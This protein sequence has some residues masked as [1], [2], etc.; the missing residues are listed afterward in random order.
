MAK[1]V[2][3]GM[4]GDRVSETKLRNAR[5]QTPTAAGGC[6]VKPP[7]DTLRTAADLGFEIGGWDEQ[8]GGLRGHGHDYVGSH[9]EIRAYL[10]AWLTCK[11]VQTLVVAQELEAQEPGIQRTMMCLRSSWPVGGG[12]REWSRQATI[13]VRPQLPFRGERI[14]IPDAIAPFFDLD[15]L[16]VGN[17]SCMPQAQSISCDLLA[18]RLDHRAA[19]EGAPLPSGA[20]AITIT[21]AATAEF[22]RAWSM[23]V[24]QVAQDLVATV[25]LKEGAPPT[26][27]EML[28][29]GKTLGR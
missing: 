11:N 3:R 15:N 22:G 2:A 20:I 13:V 5:R 23:P 25:S 28:I 12:G 4:D 14:A 1:S 7:E 17:R 16:A 24:C 19:L 8:S 29:L 27:F 10:I 9:D 21:E 6:A 26:V 18:A